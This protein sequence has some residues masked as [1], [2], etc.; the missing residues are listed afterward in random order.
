MDATRFWNHVDRS[1]PDRC[2]PWQGTITRKGYGQISDAGRTVLAHRL[3]YELVTG[4]IPDGHQVC[5]RCDNPPCVNPAHLFTGTIACENGG[6]PE[7]DDRRAALARLTMVDVLDHLACDLDEHLADLWSLRDAV[8]AE[9]VGD[10]HEAAVAGIASLAREFL[11]AVE[12]VQAM[13]TLGD[14]RR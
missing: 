4:P 2:W 14:E 12:R 6:M 9:L 3:A 8:D 7:S 10:A 13:A 1:D 11:N 5:H